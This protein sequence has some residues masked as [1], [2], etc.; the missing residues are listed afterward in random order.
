MPAFDAAD[1]TTAA[2]TPATA[3]AR[4]LF[5]GPAHRLSRVASTR[6]YCFGSV[7]RFRLPRVH[8][9]ATTVE[10]QIMHRAVF[11]RRDLHDQAAVLPRHTGCF[12][13]IGPAA[14][15]LRTQSTDTRY[16]HIR[17]MLPSANPFCCLA[18]LH[19]LAQLAIR[20]ALSG[21]LNLQTPRTS[22]WTLLW[23]NLYASPSSATW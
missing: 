15:L 5:F 4:A 7:H 1:S 3:A 17:S 10:Q 12:C 16:L 8:A 6:F 13:T 14:Q 19:D 2:N 23:D 9:S 11:V 18:P 22:C 20:S 21:T